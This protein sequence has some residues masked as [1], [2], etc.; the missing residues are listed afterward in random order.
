[1]F[2]SM[3]NCGKAETESSR[4]SQETCQLFLHD[5]NRTT[6]YS[7][8]KAVPLFALQYFNAHIVT[9]AFC[10]PL[11]VDLFLKLKTGYSNE[12]KSISRCHGWLAVQ[13]RAFG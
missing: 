6:G 1:M 13:Q 7:R 11:S 12:Q 3:E 5:Y 10:L 8:G 4:D 9:Y 2:S